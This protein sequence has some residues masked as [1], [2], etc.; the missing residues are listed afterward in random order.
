MTEKGKILR[1][2][3][4]WAASVLATASLALSPALFPAF[5]AQLGDNTKSVLANFTPAGV[6]SQLAQKFAEHMEKRAIASNRQFPFTPAGIGS[7]RNRTMTVAARTDASLG[8]NALSV[9]NALSATEQGAGKNVRLHQSDFRLSSTR[10]WQ[11][12]A[13]PVSEKLAPVPPISTIVGRGDFRLEPE[14]QK[15]SRFSTSFRIDS[16]REIA[17]S[18]RGSAAAGD[19]RLDVG[20]SFSIS[21]K[22]DVTAGVRYNSERD[23]LIPDGEN[24]Q[25]NEA[26]YIGTKI[27]F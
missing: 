16:P 13:L 19:Y 20:G 5:A 23:R 10:G 24:V 14:K 25:D 27:R 3:A 7:A 22:I 4:A 17:P 15:P 1:K 8:G 6:D 9:R 18:T 21:R 12:F 26:V 2:N 11:G